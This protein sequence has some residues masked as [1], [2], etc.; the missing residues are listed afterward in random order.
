MRQLAIKPVLHLYHNCVDFITDFAVGKGDLVLTNKL[1]YKPYFGELN[2][3]ADVVFQEQYGQGEPTDEMAEAILADLSGSYRRVIAIGGGTVID[4]AKL[5]AIRDASPV[6]DLFDRKRDLVRDKELV[7]VPTTCGTGSEMTNVSILD[8]TTRRTK[9][10]L[11]TEELF[12]DDAVLIPQLLE[13]LPYRVFAAGSIDALIHAVEAFVSPRASPY[14]RLFAK[15]AITIII[16]GY[17]T[18]ARDGEIARV[19]LL[20]DFL[21][22]SNYAGISFGNA[23]AGAVHAL[24]APLGSAFQIPH[25]E[26]NYALFTSVFAAYLGKKNSG[27]IARLG[28]ILSA[29]LGCDAKDTHASLVSLLEKILPLKPLREYGVVAADLPGFTA[30]VVSTQCRLLENGFV[31][32]SE[33]DVLGVYRACL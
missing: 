8:S 22:A 15:E 1:I 19:P 29:A 18:L 5:F 10:R 27:S 17:R 3:G 20:E 13:G 11:A 30:E 14:T 4:L 32:L 23:G 9:M 6:L 25:G 21:F 33:E 12:A 2:I 26:A 28:S 16:R 24:S 31:T 7:L